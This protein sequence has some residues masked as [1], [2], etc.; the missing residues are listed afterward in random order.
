MNKITAY[1]TI[2][3]NKILRNGDLFYEADGNLPVNDFLKGVW[4]HLQVKYP[5][6]YK[7]DTLSKL[8]VLGAEILLADRP[9]LQLSGDKTGVILSNTHSTLETDKAHWN[10]VCNHDHFYPSPAVFVYTLPNIMIGEISI[11]HKLFGENALFIT[12]RFDV[13]LL[14]SHIDLLI[15][16]GKIDAAIGGYVDVSETDYKVMMYWVTNEMKK[17]IVHDKK[18]LNQLFD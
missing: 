5:K 16:S 12:E 7:M 1:I 15:R 17:G 9:H 4:K 6:F 3:K 10:S 18:E 8:G 14:V 11:K 2:Y 13:G